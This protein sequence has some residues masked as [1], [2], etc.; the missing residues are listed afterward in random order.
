MA[1]TD[2]L[3]VGEASAFYDVAVV[4]EA[5][6]T[7]LAG[8]FVDELMSTRLVRQHQSTAREPALSSGLMY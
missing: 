5:H 3:A 8:E 4:G 7:V 2:E 6:E 1:R